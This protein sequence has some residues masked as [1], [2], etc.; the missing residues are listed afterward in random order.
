MLDQD[1]YFFISR[2]R[3][4][5]IEVYALDSNINMDVIAFAIDTTIAAG[6]IY[7]LQTKICHILQWFQCFYEIF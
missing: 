1:F 7:N 3:F 2:N 4:L 6:I 5:L